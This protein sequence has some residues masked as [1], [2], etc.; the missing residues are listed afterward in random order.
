M[1]A[2]TAQGKRRSKREPRT[3]S[4][5]GGSCLISLGQGKGGIR[6][7]S[8]PMNPAERIDHGDF[9]RDLPLDKSSLI[10]DRKKLWDTGWNKDQ[11]LSLADHAGK[12]VIL[13]FCIEDKGD[14]IYDPVA[15][16]VNVWIGTQWRAAPESLA[17]DA[18]FDDESG[19][20]DPPMIKKPIL[21][22]GFKRGPI[23]KTFGATPRGNISNQH[24][25]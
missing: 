6:G 18:A 11:A 4:S 1:A 24:C 10:F 25:R 14:T 16:I 20:I 8:L 21:C 7:G 9:F 17:Q 13:K 12:V 5:S 22:L 2:G 15:L 23:P 19:N 3:V